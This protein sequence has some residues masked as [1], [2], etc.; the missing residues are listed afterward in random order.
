MSDFQSIFLLACYVTPPAVH[1]QRRA[2]DFKSRKYEILLLS[3][4][5]NSMKS[6]LALSILD[7]I[8]IF[9][10]TFYFT[11]KDRGGGTNNAHLSISY[12]QDLRHIKYLLGY[13]FVTVSASQ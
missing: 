6:A 9:G 13:H 7:Q 3:I 11:R 4:L 5:H 2:P 8:V 10:L 1:I 12:Y